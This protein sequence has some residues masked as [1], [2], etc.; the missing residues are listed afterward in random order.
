MSI[1]KAL[2]GALGITVV[3]CVLLTI[4]KGIPT[5]SQLIQGGATMLVTSFFALKLFGDKNSTN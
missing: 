4:V 3:S 2:L 5:M 1:I